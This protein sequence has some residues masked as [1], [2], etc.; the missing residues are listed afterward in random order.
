MRTAAPNSHVL[1]RAY[2]NTV[3]IT[4]LLDTTYNHF[5]QPFKKYICYKF[6]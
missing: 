2:V 5:N 3:L 6:N 4:F 1:L